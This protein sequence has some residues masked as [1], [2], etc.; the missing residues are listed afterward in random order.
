[1]T[2]PKAPKISVI[3]PVKN[4]AGKIEPCLKAV[5]AQSLP[6]HEVIVVDGRSTDGTVARAQKFPVKVFEQDYGAAGAARQIGV[7]HAEG[8][9]LAFTDGDCIPGK[10]WLKNLVGAFGE[11]IVGVGGG[12]QNIGRGIWTKSI[13]LAFA[14]FLGSGRSVQ[15]GALFA[16]RFVKSIRMT[17]MMGTGL[18]ATPIAGG[19]ISPIVFPMTLDAAVGIGQSLS[20]CTICQQRHQRLP[21]RSSVVRHRR[22]L[23]AM[24]RGCWLSGPGIPVRSGRQP[25]SARR[26]SAVGRSCRP[27]SFLALRVVRR[28]ATVEAAR[29]ALAAS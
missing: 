4:M 2:T 13:N 10:D 20:V 9:Y 17:A 21:E 11:G 14:T 23:S 5:F 26:A 6:P 18:I 7:E 12:I 15:G 29:I 19:R 16:D 22:C 27:C 1:M 8:E 25:P 3:I 24:R 28:V